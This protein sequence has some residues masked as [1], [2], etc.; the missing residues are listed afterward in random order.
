[1]VAL[2]SLVKEIAAAMVLVIAAAA[3]VVKV[4]MVLTAQ[5]IL[6]ATAVRQAQTTTQAHL[7]RTAVAAAVLVQRRVELVELTQ[8]TVVLAVLAVLLPLIV[9]AVAA[10]VLLTLLVAQA[11]QVESCFVR[12][13]LRLRTSR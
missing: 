7:F 13:P 4:G 5:G 2:V 3:A 12:S 9:V 8:V 11:A 6:A 1:L 10:A